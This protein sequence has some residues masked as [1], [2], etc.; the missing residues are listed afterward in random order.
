M[1]SLAAP[2]PS[3]PTRLLARC[4]SPT[5]FD[6]WAGKLN[7]LW[8]LQQPLARLVAR[9]PAGAGAAT[10]V[11]RTNRHW[12]G[13]R[14]GQHVTLGVEIDGRR[15]QRSYS[16]TVLDRRHIAVTVKAVEGGQVS[17]HLVETAPIGT[18]FALDQAFGDMLLPAQPQPLL[19]LAAGSGITPMRALL[20]QLAVQG[21]PVAVDLLYWARRAED[22][23]FADELQALAAA[24][25]GLR[26]QLLATRDPQAPAA[27][28]DAH[29]LE[30]VQGLALRQVFACGPGGF[31]AAARARLAGA[32]AGFAAEA[33]SLDP[34]AGR[35]DGEVEVQLARSGRSLRLP[36]GR[37]L[38]E[39][40]EAQGI[41]P[42]HGCRMGI[43]NSCACA[44][45]SGATRHVLTGEHSN[46][47]SAQVRLCVSAPSTD[48]ILDL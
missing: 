11:L 25:P 37:S 12:R 39:G 20:R 4:V 10:L 24:H 34:V 42:R 19:L 41:R 47:P 7:A 32:V 36:R 27:R 3:F 18:V 22:F 35:E 5:L 28:I 9:Q 8:S 16:P 14:A 33:F 17:R 48:L 40:L 43:C 23:C 1:N 29:P 38:L 26:V 15:L 46:E 6:F 30:Q 31:V 21:M 44:R 13:M 2:A 45:R